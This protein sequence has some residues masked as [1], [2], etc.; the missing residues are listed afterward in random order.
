MT[1]IRTNVGRSLATNAIAGNMWEDFSS[2]TYKDLPSAGPIEVYNPFSDR[3]DSFLAPAGGRGYYRPAS[4]VGIWATA[5]YLHNNSLGL[6]NNNPSV[7]G[8]MQAFDDSI[9]KLL[10]N[11]GADRHASGQPLSPAERLSLAAERR[12]ALHVD[13]AELAN[14]A[15]PQRMRS[16]HGLIWRT[17]EDTWLRITAENL[18]ELL[19]R[20]TGWRLAFLNRYP[21]LPAVA[22]LALGFL[23]LAA[24]RPP[25]RFAIVLKGLGLF[26]AVGAVGLGFIGYFLAGRLGGLE[27]GPIPAGTP[28]NLLANVDPDPSRQ[29]EVIKALIG[30]R[31]TMKQINKAGAGSDEGRRLMN[32]LGNGLLR[33]S[34]CPDLVMDRGHYFAMDLT[35]AEIEDLIRL[36][37]T[38]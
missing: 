28:V 29:K 7:D 12:I 17:P 9:R 5:P 38:F 27:I 10:V 18:P 4:L 26:L 1:L 8:R 32:E 30:A 11:A 37:K 20:L 19:Q 6:F 16:D 13:P 33:V 14:G 35:D 31:R 2:Q 22:A 15:T 36:L 24:S 23:S 34:K 3:T 21:W 25:R